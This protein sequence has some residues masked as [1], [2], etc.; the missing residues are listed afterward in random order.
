MN[1]DNNQKG[2]IPQEQPTTDKKRFEKFIPKVLNIEGGLS[3]NKYDKGGATKFG[4]SL[5]FLKANGIDINK[6]GKID[7]NDILALDVD[8]AK[9]LYYD[10]FYSKM[11]I[12]E[13]KDEKIAINVFDMG[14]NSGIVPAVRLLQDTLNR[15]GAS[16]K[17]DGII[18]AKTLDAVNK[19]EGDINNTYCEERINY[20]ETICLRDPS[21]RV[22]LNGW[23]NRVKKFL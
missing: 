8:R 2:N 21:Q 14:I 17:V 5:A 6:D 19:A 11:K 18:G 20:Y 3:F 13:I 10:Y 16:L 15:H 23:K 12:D 7:Q 1:N 4:I 9:Q 22:F